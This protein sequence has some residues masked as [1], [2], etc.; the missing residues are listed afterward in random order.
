MKTYQIVMLVAYGLGILTMIV[1]KALNI[2]NRRRGV[3]KMICSAL[4]V[5]MAIS[6]AV[7]S[8]DRYKVFALVGVIF[9]A[10]GDLFLVFMDKHELFVCGVLSFSVAS[11]CFSIYTSLSFDWHWWFLIVFILFISAIVAGQLTKVIDFGRSLVY[12]NLYTG[13]VAL[14]GCLGLTLVFNGATANVHAF[15]FGL[16]SF[17]YFASDIVLGLFLYKFHS[18]VMDCVNT[19]LYFPGL[20]L[21]ALAL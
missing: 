3:V 11:L 14:C 13:F 16:G 1:M 15:L 21:I 9:A 2:G 17:M 5:A 12:L 6:Q 4:F 8:T 7:G 10:L 20:M 19:A 18:P